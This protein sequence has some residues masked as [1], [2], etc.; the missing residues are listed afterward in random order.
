MIFTTAVYF[1]LLLENKFLPMKSLFEIMQVTDHKHKGQS[2]WASQAVSLTTSNWPRDH[3]H[4]HTTDKITWMEQISN[5]CRL[6]QWWHGSY[7]SLLKTKT[8][9]QNLGYPCLLMRHL[10]ITHL[11][12]H[13]LMPATV[14]RFCS[15]YFYFNATLTTTDDKKMW[16]TLDQ[17]LF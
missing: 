14:F 9:I 8:P 2:P 7:I 6:Y 10:E 1:V 16:S 3:R 17:S 11:D 13:K 4:Q 5:Q 15:H 12:I